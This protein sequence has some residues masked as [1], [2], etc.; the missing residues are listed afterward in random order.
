[1]LDKCFC[2]L[3]VILHEAFLDCVKG[4]IINSYKI[5]CKWTLYQIINNCLVILRSFCVFREPK[6]SHEK[7]PHFTSLNTTE[8]G[9]SVVQIILTEIYRNLSRILTGT[10]EKIQM[11]YYRNPSSIITETLEQLLQ[12]LQNNYYRNLHESFLDCVKGCIMYS[13]ESL[14]LIVHI[15]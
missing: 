13:Y 12:K 14:Y 7:M 4:C 6:A 11:K 3:S 2:N 8:V 9:S 5:H 10:L 15:Q 1:M